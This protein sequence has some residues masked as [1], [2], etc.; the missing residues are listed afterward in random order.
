MGLVGRAFEEAAACAARAAQPAYLREV[1]QAVDLLHQSLSGAHRLLVF[2]NGGSAADALHIAGDLIGHFQKTRDAIPAIALAAN[3][4]VLTA[5][6]ND[7]EFAT[8]FARQVEALGR[9][10]DVAWGISTSGNSL[11]VVTALRRARELGLRT[12][13]LTGESGG[14]M[15]DHCD[16]VIRAPATET[17]RIQEVHVVT[18]HA[19]C[20]ELESRLFGEPPS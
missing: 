15:V 18:Y 17:P 12:I 5:W 8:V 10:G 19:I 6:S 11:N 16:V 4:A 2:G 1:E 9:P 3:Q 13:G 7:H 14:A 20:A